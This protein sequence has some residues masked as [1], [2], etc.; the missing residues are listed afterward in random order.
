MHFPAC[1]TSKWHL[2]PSMILFSFFLAFAHAVLLASDSPLGLLCVSKAFRLSLH[3]HQEASCPSRL[4]SLHCWN[5]FPLFHALSSQSQSS[6]VL[7]YSTAFYL[8]HLTMCSLRTK[9]MFFNHFCIYFMSGMQLVIND[10]VD[11]LNTALHVP[12]E[13]FLKH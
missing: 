2:S 11:W 6:S 10:I 4:H 1:E 9:L 13:E 8:F 5:A 12:W 3:L 7:C